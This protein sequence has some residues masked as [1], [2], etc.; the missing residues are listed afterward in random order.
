[1]ADPR[2]DTGGLWSREVSQ[3]YALSADAVLRALATDSAGLPSLEAARRLAEV[4]PNRLPEPPRE[5]PV[6]RFLR[7]FDDVL[8][9]ILLA[10]AVLKAVL[11][12]WVDF[13]VI[14][15][16]AVV[17]AVIGFVQEG[18]A[19]QALEG[20]RTMLS[21]H[22]HVRRDGAW[23]EVEADEVVPGDV[24]RVRSGDRVPADVRLIEA[25]N[26][27][28][29]ES[30]LTGEAVPSAK[31]VFPVKSDAGVGDRSSMLFSG[32]LVAGGNGLGVVTATGPDA[33][34][35]RIQTMIA[36]VETFETPLTRELTTFGKRL[37]ALILGL[38]AVMVVIGQALHDFEVPELIS[39]AIGFAVA[40]IP[41]GLP[42]LV[43]ITLAL[44]VQQ[45]ARRNAITRRLTAV[46]ALGSVTTICSDK[47]GTLTKN[48]MTVRHVVT[49]RGR[50]DVQGLGYEPTGEVTLDGTQVPPIGAGAPPDLAAL[51]T[52]MGLCNDAQVVEEDGR[53][54]VLGEPTEGAL[55]TLARK[56]GLS[57]KGHE[58]L[59]VV[60]FESE[61][62]Y[63][64]TLDRVPDG[65]V[66]VLLKGAPDR[67]LDRSSA[68][69]RADGSTEPLDRAFWEGEVDA[70]SGQGLRVLAAASRPAPDAS[71][72]DHDAVAAGMTLLG[73]VGIVDPPRPDAVA[74]IATCHAA[75]IAVK[76]ITG[77]HAGTAS[78]IGREM[79]LVRGE[80]APVITGTELEAS[81]NEQLKGIVARYDV[82]AR[83]S[84][85]HKLRIV[86]ALQ[87][88]GQ[89]VAMTGDGVNDAPAL[90]R[91]EVGVAMGIKGTEATKE[92]A[93]L[94]LADDNFS[95]IEYAVEEG[96]RIYDNLQKSVVFLLPTNGAQSLVILVAVLLGL[97]LPLD[98]VQ[99]LWVNMVTA[100]TLSLALAYEP[101]EA[102]IMSRPPRRPGASMIDPSLLAQVLFVSLLIGAATLMAFEI[103]R[104][105]DLSLAASQTMAVNTLVLAQA[106]YL[107]STRFLRQSSLRV[108]TLTTNPVVW[109]S[110]A[111]LVVVQAVF[112]YAPFMHSWFGSAAVGPREWLLPLGL[113]LAVFLLVEVGKAVARSRRRS[114][115]GR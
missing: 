6:L 59:A 92:A 17:N 42:A 23:V 4:G 83:T 72:L 8:I 15:V 24:V 110:V 45:M 114:D 27:R 48:E 7:H 52:V 87:A 100:V 20:I 50:Y 56:A 39:A 75:G 101:A 38:A 3:A 111:A 60:P 9:Y 16:V 82:F 53:W 47:T 66:V 49:Q 57:V 13:W 18:R 107:F 19:E 44:G 70:L 73:V 26:L 81:T 109:I 12:D 68:Q 62:K 34:I 67:L 94:V 37:S 2:P 112:V 36:E 64:A 22:A 41:E 5:H 84:P 106:T 31:S 113:A 76:M 32:T 71:T 98:P 69:G 25:V 35:G 33:E 108:D 55:S 65:D 115:A 30:A 43:T 86:K 80:D 11:S 63:M 74:A 29:E 102:D 96:R 21:M 90:K 85:E 105:W 97:T 103:A 99:I 79:G 10:A 54:R 40:A 89:V 1:M 88:N 51:V 28:V 93:E 46:E 61:H 58:R 91:S 95:S 77:D 78:A 104:S 14:L